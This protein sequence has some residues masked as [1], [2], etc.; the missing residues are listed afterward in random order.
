MGKKLQF[1]IILYNFSPFWTILDGHSFK[2][3][4]N[5]KILA[6]GPDDMPKSQLPSKIG[7]G[8]KV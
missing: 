5:F 4:V 8:P 1:W 2:N 6:K 3:M 7:K